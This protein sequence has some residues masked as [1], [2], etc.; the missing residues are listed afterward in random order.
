[1]PARSDAVRRAIDADL[2]IR[3]TLFVAAFLIAWISLHPFQ[4]LADPPK[5]V[6]EGG[7]T[8][9]QIGYSV[10]FIVLAVWATLHEPRRLLL[11]LRPVLTLTLLWSAVSVVASWEPS[12]AA[13]RL[14]FAL[15][16]LSISAMI[17][18]LPKNLRH[19]R[20]LMALVA[21]I[22]LTACYLGV[23][24]A[25]Q[26]AIH[27]ATDF[28]EPEHAG[29]WR[30]VFPHKNEAGATMVLLIFIGIFVARAHRALL[31]GAIVFLATVFLL[32][33]QSKNAIG[34][35]PLVFLVSAIVGRRRSPV[36]S[37]LLVIAVVAALNLFSVG[38][39]L[40]EPI[41]KLVGSVMPD[42]TFTGRTEIWELALQY[43]ARRPL[44]GCGFSAFW[45]TPQV[46][47]GIG[48]S[49]SW[50]NAASDA[51]NA[52]VNLALGI[53]LPGLALVIMWVV[54]L[55]IVDYFRLSSLRRPG[56]PPLST[57]FL[58]VCLYGAFASCFE[59][60]IFT[61][62][63]E[64]WFLYVTSAFGLCYLARTAVIE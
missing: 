25:P 19:F 40:F 13:R 30:G 48:E 5:A 50:V 35:L 54:V 64:V 45:G 41:R 60:S 51:H 36:T 1:M 6:A 8:A 44:T 58:R 26:L 4:S 18:L 46:V 47:Y 57:L 37:V 29:S 15:I 42:A 23:V 34:M 38:T 2:L 31:G 62:L 56:A 9:N 32:F 16:F 22:V 61:P 27:Q 17:L 43:I 14:A 20:D 59:S 10:L 28:L 55:P 12:L 24:F 7:D 63:G 3:S 21:I 33:T 11:L 39:V 49:A 53:G 52:Y